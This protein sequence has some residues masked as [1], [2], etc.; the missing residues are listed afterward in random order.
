MKYQDFVVQVGLLPGGLL[1]ARVLRSPAGEGDHVG[2]LPP[3]LEEPGLLAGDWLVRSEVPESASRILVRRTK[4]PAPQ[5]GELGGKLH[6]L[7]FSGKVGR[8][9]DQSLGSLRGRRENGLRLRL[10]ID[11]GTAAGL[12]ELPWELL[13]RGDTGSYLSLDRQ[14]PVLRHLEVAQPVLPLLLPTTLKVLGVAA[15]PRELAGLD[16]ARERQ[17]LESQRKSARRWQV[18]F[19]AKPTVEELRK[20]LMAEGSHVLHFMGHGG[21]DPELQE[22]VLYFEDGHGNAAPWTGNALAA[23]L[24]GISS[25]RLVV[26]NA[27]HTATTG[28]RGNLFGGVAAALVRS[29]L[30]AVIAMQ[31]P[32]SD[33]AA[34]AFSQAFYLQLAAGAGLEEALTEGRQ[35]IH[36]L[37][38][39][40]PEWAI[41]VLF[42]R[43]AA[44]G[45]FEV[46]DQN[47][48][49]RRRLVAFAVGLGLLLTAGI[50]LLKE[51][52]GGQKVY[53]IEIDQIL[54]SGADGLEARIAS[55][56]ILPDGR[57]RLHFA[58]DNR[59]AQSRLLGFDFKRSYMADE[60]GN[61]Y[62]IKSSSA[63][64]PTTESLLETVPAGESREYWVEVEAPFDG[65]RRLHVEMA[66]P[67]RSEA[68][69]PP[70][71]VSLPA[72]PA[73]WS[74]QAPA[75]PPLEGAET[76]A[77]AV[78]VDTGR[79]DVFSQIHQV[80]VSER[81]IRLSF[82]LWNRGTQEVTAE[83]DPAGIVLRDGKGNL[84]RP[85]RMGTFEDGKLVD[86]SVAT[87][88]R[89]AVRT[90]LFVE[91]PPPMAITHQWE[92]ELA[93]RADSD[94][95]FGRVV[96]QLTE[97]IFERVRKNIEEFA[98]RAQPKLPAGPRSEP[99]APKTKA[100][101]VP[102]T[103]TPS[104]P[105][106][107]VVPE[108]HFEIA[109]G[110]QE[111]KTTREGLKAKVKSVERLGNGRLR[112]R[113]E[114]ANLG[115]TTLEIPLRLEGT[116]LSDEDGRQFRL[117]AS[118]FGEAGEGAPGAVR[119]PLSAGATRELTFEFSGR[120][121]GSSL[122]T[123]V[124]GSADPDSCRFLPI[125]THLPPE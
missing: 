43:T 96:L 4:V 16:L 107:S 54:A 69:L 65:A 92:L 95:R 88:L 50:P 117:L 85:K 8:L 46:G 62:R 59:G 83:F 10:Q 42:S 23:K 102:A 3:W 5:P 18:A 93:T 121:K 68:T 26:L 97:G 36:T 118:T 51:G 124:L 101:A 78:T 112:F 80:E 32:I 81:G 22:G 76:L 28:N 58:F 44:G 75:Q 53:A 34:I 71:E 20:S 13:F 63:P 125:R 41:P 19:L 31:Q 119:F 52:F 70:F 106:V 105:V 33:A 64:V 66:A 77:M 40:S 87:E 25:L 12:A 98:R 79:K 113:V 1:Q 89:R 45:L 114:F 99:E 108:L 9:W 17:E 30:P 122:F 115:P 91:F 35:A 7:L 14:T 29:G 94:F 38:P 82:D 37:K 72:Y 123:F 21:F 47:P 120:V 73:E 110:E 60:F 100:A 109:E 39:E 104:P 56:E 27:C 74:R 55:V 116:K 48:G 90:R 2:P 15:A 49:R 24:A 57:M 6:D 61:A 84:L 67:D 103:S 86:L 111:V 11:L